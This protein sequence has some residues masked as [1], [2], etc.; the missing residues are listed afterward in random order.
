MPFDPNKIHIWKVGEGPWQ[1]ERKQNNRTT[2]L[3]SLGSGSL[4]VPSIQATRLLPT[5]PKL[6]GHIKYENVSVC[7]CV[8]ET[9]CLY[10]NNCNTKIT[11]MLKRDTSDLGDIFK[12]K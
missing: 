2:L 1:D 10:T 11:T 8:C 12:D 9:P 7:V 5:T 6:W 3:L 4:T